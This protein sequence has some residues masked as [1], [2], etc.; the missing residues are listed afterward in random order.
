MGIKADR[1][2]TEDVRN[3]SRTQGSL[4]EETMREQARGQGSQAWHGQRPWTRLA[5]P[6]FHSAPPR[7]ASQLP[8]ASPGQ[9]SRQYLF[10]PFLTRS[11]ERLREVT[12]TI[13]DACGSTYRDVGPRQ[14]IDAMHVLTKLG[15][16]PFPVFIVVSDKQIGVYHFMQEGLK[17]KTNKFVTLLK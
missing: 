16:V 5:V 15:A 14:A 3:G 9:P 7:P 11:Q 12:V 4:E 1:R 17:Q 13:T 10:S 2:G 8:Q 6:P